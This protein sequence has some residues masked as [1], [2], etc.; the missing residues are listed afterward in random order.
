MAGFEG[1]GAKK[2]AV[3]E[4]LLVMRIY[5]EE[6][7]AVWYADCVKIGDDNEIP[8]ARKTN[9]GVVKANAVVLFTLEEME[10][11]TARYELRARVKT[12]V[13]G[14]VVFGRR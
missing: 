2:V 4:G 1:R 6:E 11:D 10:E 13:V 3:E 12:T 8:A 7:R 9:G 14:L 5:W